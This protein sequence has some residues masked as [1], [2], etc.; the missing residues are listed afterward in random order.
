VSR[1]RDDIR[2]V[3]DTADLPPERVHSREVWHDETGGSLLHAPAWSG[4]FRDLIEG[5]AYRTQ[6]IHGLE[7][8]NHPTLTKLEVDAGASCPTCLNSGRRPR[9]EYR[10]RRPQHAAD[11]RLA[12]DHVAV[13]LPPFDVVLRALRQCRGSIAETADL[14]A[15]TWP[16]MAAPPVAVRHIAEACRRYRRVF[17]DEPRDRVTGP[18]PERSES[19]NIAEAEG[20]AA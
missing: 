7:M 12:R 8:C 11:E 10:F 2:F 13:G 9:V 1:L 14:L 17:R 4:E 16:K 18:R 15:A 3:L 20:R 6:T 5:D 19:Q